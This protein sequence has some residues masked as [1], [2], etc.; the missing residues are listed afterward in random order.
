MK[1]WILTLSSILYL[2]QAC[3]NAPPKSVNPDKQLLDSLIQDAKWELY[4]Y[5][6]RG[7]FFRDDKLP[8]YY[9]PYKDTIRF[10]VI[11]TSLQHI[12]KSGAIRFISSLII[13]TMRKNTSILILGKRIK[14]CPILYFLII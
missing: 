9:L 14:K 8:E 12:C 3:R 4:K 5:N 10:A 6:Y 7:F 13:L 2:A 1:I 11:A